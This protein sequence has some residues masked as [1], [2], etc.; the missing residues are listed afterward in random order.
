MEA[1]EQMSKGRKV[2]SPPVDLI[3][4]TMEALFCALRPAMMILW[5]TA[6]SFAQAAPR[7][8]VPPMT[9]QTF[10]IVKVRRLGRLGVSAKWEKQSQF[11][12][13]NR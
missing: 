5:S 4:W 12:L 7:P 11:R 1:G 3:V 2:A 8:P 6:R 13:R 9:R 10:D